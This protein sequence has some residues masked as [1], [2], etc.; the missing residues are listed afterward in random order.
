MK[1]KMMMYAFNRFLYM[2]DVYLSV[3]SRLMMVPM[4][5]RM[6]YI[7]RSAVIT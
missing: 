6:K 1:R 5:M 7:S 4:N 2:F 3:S